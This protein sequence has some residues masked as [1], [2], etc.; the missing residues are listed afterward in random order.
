[1]TKI[2]GWY[3][4]YKNIYKKIKVGVLQYIMVKNILN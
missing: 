3:I 4:G 1:M 2:E